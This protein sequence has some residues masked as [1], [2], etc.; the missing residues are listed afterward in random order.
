MGHEHGSEYQLRVILLNG[1]EIMTGWVSE[2]KLSASIAA[3]QE[4]GKTCWVQVRR[5]LCH[6]C[7]DQEQ[8]ISE[9]PVAGT[10]SS[11][12]L[13]HDSRYLKAA[14][15]RNRGEISGR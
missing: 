7:P 10:R 8:S 6:S 5:V 4:K 14:G 1:K 3:A 15:V 11:R 12:H 13:P 2:E 9:Y